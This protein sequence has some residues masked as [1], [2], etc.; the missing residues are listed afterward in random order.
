MKAQPESDALNVVGVLAPRVG[1]PDAE[2]LL[3]DGDAAVAP[4]PGL[5]EQELR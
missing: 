3:A 5:A 4:A 1:L 2:F